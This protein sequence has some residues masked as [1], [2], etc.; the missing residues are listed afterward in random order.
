MLE[1]RGRLEM[2]SQGMIRETK[3]IR[4]DQRTSPTEDPLR[5]SGNNVRCGKE[6]GEA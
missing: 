4:E 3:E 1:G 6:V 5:G 2:K